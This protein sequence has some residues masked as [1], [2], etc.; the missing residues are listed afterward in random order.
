MHILGAVVIILVIVA[1]VAMLVALGLG[2]KG[3]TVH[4]TPQ[5]TFLHYLADASTRPPDRKPSP[6]PDHTHEEVDRR[7]EV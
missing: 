5:R 6:G 2:M 4:Q 7:T 3:R 1:G